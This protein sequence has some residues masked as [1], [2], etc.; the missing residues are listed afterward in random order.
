METQHS[1]IRTYL[2]LYL[3]ITVLAFGLIACKTHPEGN[4]GTLNR[5]G[6]MTVR[7]YNEQWEKIDSLAKE[8]LV[9]SALKALEELEEIIW[10]NND[11]LQSI[12]SLIYYNKFQTQ[13]EEDSYEEA[14]SRFEQALEKYRGPHKAIVHSQLGE[15]Y[16]GYLQSRIYEISS[17]TELADQESGD[18][19]NWDATRLIRHINMHFLASLDPSTRTENADEYSVLLTEKHWADTLRPTLYDILAHRAIDYFGKDYAYLV[20]PVNI[21]RADQPEFFAPVESFYAHQFETP[22]STNYL[23]RTVLLFQE[24]LRFRSGQDDLAAL[25]DADLKRIEFFY[26]RS[27]VEDK[28]SLYLKSIN[29]I[30][31]TVKGT[32]H[33]AEVIYQLAAY[34]YQKGQQ[35]QAGDPTTDQ[36]RWDL[37][38]AKDL[39]ESAVQ[40]YPESYGGNR[41]KALLKQI[42]GKSLEIRL[43]EVSLGGEAILGYLRYRNI[44]SLS[45]RIVRLSHDVEDLRISGSQKEKEQ[46]L[47]GISPIRTW[48]ITVPDEGDFQMHAVEFPIESLEH[49]RYALLVTDSDFKS[50]NATLSFQEFQVSGLAFFQSRT[51]FNQGNYLVVNRHTGV[52]KAGVKVEFYSSEYAPA[53]R[54]QQWNLIGSDISDQ[55]GAV[56]LASERG[57]RNIFLRLAFEGDTLF[58]N[59]NFSQYTYTAQSNSSRRV[60]LFLDR[61]IYR[62]GQ[63]IYFKGYLM[64]F[65][66]DGMPSIMTNQRVAVRLHDANR[67]E[68]ESE[69]F[70]TN[71]F[72]TFSGSFKS[73]E[74]GLK[75]R[76]SLRT[77]VGHASNWFMVEEYKRPTFEVVIDTPETAIRLGK[78]VIINGKGQAYAGASISGAQYSYRIVRRVYYPYFSWWRSSFPGNGNQRE[79]AHG[80][81]ITSDDG[82]FEFTFHAQPDESVDP[83]HN[84]TFLFEITVDITDITGETRSATYNLNLSFDAFRAQF[85]IE[86]Y[87]RSDD[88][89][90]LEVAMHSQSGIPLDGNVT[91]KAT[92][93]LGPEQPQRE[94][95][96]EMPDYTLLD[97]EIFEDLFPQYTLPVRALIADWPE[98]EVVGS[99]SFQLKGETTID[100]TKVIPTPGSYKIEMTFMHGPDTVRK[101]VYSTV[102]AIGNGLPPHMLYRS[103]VEPGPNQPGETV[104]VTQLARD[105]GLFVYHVFD[106]KR[107]IREQWG[108]P[109]DNTVLTT[110]VTEQDRGGFYYHDIL[111]YDNRYYQSTHRINVPWTNKQLQIEW[112]SYRDKTLPGAEEEWRLKISGPDKDPVAAE[113]LA[114]MYDAS[115]DA[116]LQHDWDLSLYPSA[117]SYWSSRVPGFYASHN[118]FLR[119]QWKFEYDE[120]MTKRYRNLNWF[121]FYIGGYG[122]MMNDQ[123]RYLRDG[124]SMEDA[125]GQPPPAAESA[126]AEI[127]EQDLS[128]Q[129]KPET[130]DE[131]VSPEPAPPIQ[132]R[133]DLDETVFF[134]P[135]IETDREGNVILRF[136][137]KEALTRWKFQGIAHTKD[138]K[139]ALTEKSIVTQKDLMVFPNPP[140]FLRQGDSL[141]FPVKVSNLS[142]EA[143]KGEVQLQILDAATDE[144]ISAQFG[145]RRNSKQFATIAGGS[146]VAGFSLAVPSDR[147]MPVKYR[148][149]ARAGNIGDGQED[150]LPVV[151]NRILVTETRPMTVK[152]NEVKR[153]TFDHLEN[154][155]SATLEHHSYTVEFTENP[156]WYVVQALPYLMEYPHECSEQIFSRLYAN[157]LGSHIVESIP[158][159]KRVF[160]RWESEPEKEGLLSK[161]SQNQELKSALLEETPWVLESASEEEQRR[162]MALLFDMHRMAQQ[163]EQ[164]V[165]KLSR[166][167]L[168]NGGFPWFAGGRDNWYITQYI[169]EGFGHLD[170]LGVLKG[171]DV[172]GL[173]QMQAQMIRYLDER[174]AEHYQELLKENPK[175][176]NE[177]H[178]TALIAHY[179]YTRTFFKQYER[180]SEVSEAWTY[181]M[182]QAEEYWTE[183]SLYEQGLIALAMVR[184]GK[185]NIAGRIGKSIAER[186]LFSEELGRYWKAPAGMFWYQFPVE[187]QAMMIELFTDLGHETHWIDEM[188]L[189][190]LRNKQT[191]RWNNTKSTAA[192]IYAFLLSG[193][194]WL[195]QQEP[196]TIIAG[197]QMLTADQETAQAGTGYIKHRWEG[198]EVTSSLARVHV[199][200]PN[201]HL[202]WGALYWQYFEDMDRVEQDAGMSL[203]LRKLISIE[204]MTDRGPV[205][206]K[207][208]DETKIEVGDKIVVRVEL[209]VDRPME[210]VH[211]K[212]HR[213]SGLEPVD[214]LSSYKWQGGLGY[215][216]S[217]GDLSTDFFIDY[218]PRGHWVLEYSLRAQQAGTFNNG[219]GT[220]QCMYAPEFSS[221][222]E[223]RTLRIEQKDSS[224]N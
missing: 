177:D 114:S 193:S 2:T 212:D 93:I 137:M 117:R 78:Q 151:S 221:H 101:T 198:K 21:F 51:Q 45:L 61:S 27:K 210:F 110:E 173:E 197:N 22:D 47:L 38:T 172:K 170:K 135:H 153:F 131:T 52:P 224:G 111:F 86:E 87:V 124:V 219:I 150:L 25:A 14:L 66:P 166:L 156:A 155:K 164:A 191:N 204:R 35:Y 75:G 148:A 65:D 180:S 73:P 1:F 72:G 34:Y 106:R 64:E 115:L 76:M 99:G 209:E 88:L 37:L 41:S 9:R 94:R 30:R 31:E 125:A 179:L 28:D 44:E 48:H 81:G 53:L 43:E 123:V 118:Q 200:N 132:I 152:A 58:L 189:W 74:T 167:Q 217:T 134:F 169:A 71:A 157:I 13:I 130:P 199:T 8:G 32:S 15:L 95:Y 190:L 82:A 208:S 60:F 160:E 104:A 203:Q 59:E 11:T 129:K 215:Y 182:Q 184:D 121:G 7:E 196:V 142:S 222:T 39:A 165:G 213:A 68:R 24:L 216:Q 147:I 112:L 89:D 69:I 92:R 146:D 49:G 145:I 10:E 149:I 218:L 107:S 220:L 70:T 97:E 100:L 187:R 202:A 128:S 3:T 83:D 174:F 26:H 56:E 20:E 207:V 159:I 163:T 186:S 205:L 67:K 80:T 201:N 154:I 79:I 223:G 63:T 183:K 16:A 188:R 90:T 158:S 178:L 109:N 105:I 42:T 140:R 84:P 162:R 33:E 141:V 46:F 211:F 194:D 6:H 85:R 138:L 91:I 195:S 139:Y 113:F 144:D 185:A 4:T 29:R 62:P 5:K 133:K 108:E 136:K 126:A 36:Y 161:L 102:L 96:W 57:A 54:K 120:A 12:K 122:V 168:S 192:A 98:A 17:R 175:D 171:V 55:E 127:E 119:Y 214:V 143:L 181:F 206:E 18:I 50:E 116:F 40:Q 176:L 23:F 103:I 19:R 77:D